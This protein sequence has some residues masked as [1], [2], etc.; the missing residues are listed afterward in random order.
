[1]VIITSSLDQYPS[2]LIKL[3]TGQL[4]NVSNPDDWTAGW[5]LV[6]PLLI[7]TAVVMLPFA[8]T[9]CILYRER[10]AEERRQSPGITS[11]P[12]TE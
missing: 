12:P 6:F 2:T 11:Q 5:S 1:M 4:P 9:Y 10:A 7:V 3:V 8:V